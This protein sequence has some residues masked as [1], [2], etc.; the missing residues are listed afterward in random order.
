M[1]IRS[2]IQKCLMLLIAFITLYSCNQVN[3]SS[4]EVEVENTSFAKKVFAN[5]DGYARTVQNYPLAGVLVKK[6]EEVIAKSNKEG[7]F[8]I[9]G[10]LGKGDVLTFE[11]PKFVSVTKVLSLDSKLII[12][13]KERGESVVF[14]SKRGG[15]LKLEKGGG[16]IIPPNAFSYNGRAYFGPVEITASYIDV[17]D[18][19]EVRAAPGSYVAFDAKRNNLVP[20]ASFGMIEVNA[21]IPRE[22]IPLELSEGSA[23]QANFPVLNKETPEVVNLYEFDTE[24]GY[25]IEA[26]EL[27]N[28]QNNVL[29]GEITTV[30]SSWNA[31]EPCSETLVCVK[32]KVLFANGN[33]GCGVGATGVTYDGFD[34][35]HSIG[36][37]DYV[38]L[39]VCPDSVFELGACWILCCGPG[40]PSSD[41]CCNNPQYRTTIDM[42]TITLDPSGCTDIGTWIV[43]N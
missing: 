41:P 37:D 24:I 8:V 17:T 26:G 18:E 15:E 36:P 20:L 27:I 40:V 19:D 12:W 6:G 1:K 33:P 23:I 38:E 2:I 14:D 29:Q 5:Y 31:D 10:K 35:I 4:P 13:M 28:I 7:Y 22:N 30:N 25:W 42:S 9:E 21:V 39:M 16:L 3:T 32:V 43:P 34:G 11:H